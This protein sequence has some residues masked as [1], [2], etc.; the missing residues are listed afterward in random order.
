MLQLP[1]PPSMRPLG[2]LHCVLSS[3][4][5][6]G[7]LGPLGTSLVF[8]KSSELGRSSAPWLHLELLMPGSHLPGKCQNHAVWVVLEL[9]G[10][11]QDTRITSYRFWP[12][13]KRTAAWYES[14]WYL[15][16]SGTKEGPLSSS[17]LQWAAPNNSEWDT[18]Q[19]ALNS[20]I[21]GDLGW[22]TGILYTLSKILTPLSHWGKSFEVFHWT[23]WDF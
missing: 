20:E 11:C 7:E 18:S 21:W 15:I 22:S 17:G 9:Y 10:C 14:S 16:N 3:T 2:Y 4:A 5:R 6:S 8:H 23:Q 19:S 1:F 12:E 13:W